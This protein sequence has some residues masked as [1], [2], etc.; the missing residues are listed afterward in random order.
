MT[1]FVII[2]YYSRRNIYVRRI[3]SAAGEKEEKKKKRFRRNDSAYRCTYT[4]YTPLNHTFIPYTNRLP[5]SATMQ[6]KSPA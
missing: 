5:R 3:V 6:I 1:I 2:I 4:I